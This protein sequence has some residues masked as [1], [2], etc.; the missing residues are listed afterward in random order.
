LCGSGAGEE[1][2]AAGGKMPMVVLEQEEEARKQRGE[3][4]KKLQR[5][6]KDR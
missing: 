3:D 2:E 5:N 1:S 6:K 4:F